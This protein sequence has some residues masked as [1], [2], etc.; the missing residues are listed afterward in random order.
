MGSFRLRSRPL[1]LVLA[2]EHGP[3]SMLELCLPSRLVQIDLVTDH[4]YHS[5]R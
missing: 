1:L 4:R 3:L 5:T 2:Q